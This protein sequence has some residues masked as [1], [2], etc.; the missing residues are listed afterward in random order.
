MQPNRDTVKANIRLRRR[1]AIGKLYAIPEQEEDAREN[2][3]SLRCFAA[4]EE[5]YARRAVERGRPI[6]ARY[7]E[8]EAREDR[9]RA[10]REM[11]E[12]FEHTERLRDESRRCRHAAAVAEWELREDRTDVCRG[13]GNVFGSCD[14]SWSCPGA[15]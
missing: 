1:V 5:F 9:R 3:R 10:C 14:G 11:R 6:A 4:E 7:R 13:C 8:N 2:A 15:F 12:M